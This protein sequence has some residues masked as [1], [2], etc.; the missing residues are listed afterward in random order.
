MRREVADLAAAGQPLNIPRLGPSLNAKIIA[1]ALTGRLPFYDQL[2]AGLTPA[3]RRLLTVPGIG[4]TL[5]ARIAHDLGPD[6]SDLAERLH[7]AAADGSLR[8]IW[9]IGKQRSA[10]ILAAVG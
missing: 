8:R 4:P 5:A 2:L 6:D 7:R 1:L 3:E 9:G 10:A